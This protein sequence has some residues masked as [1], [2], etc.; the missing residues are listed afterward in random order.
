M[1]LKLEKNIFRT[2][3]CTICLGVFLTKLNLASLYETILGD[4]IVIAVVNC[5][6]NIYSVMKNYYNDRPLEHRCEELNATIGVTS[7]IIIILT[8]GTHLVHYIQTKLYEPSFFT[9]S[10]NIEKFASNTRALIG[11][12]GLLNLCYAAIIV[13]IIGLLTII[14]VCRECLCCVK[15]RILSNHRQGFSLEH[16]NNILQGPD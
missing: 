11:L 14:V 9:T 2:I 16:E 3:I 15:R 12:I 1:L 13:L 7:W 10:P 6:F 4:I 5:I 8:I